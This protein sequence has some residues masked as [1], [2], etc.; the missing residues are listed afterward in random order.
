MKTMND[1]FEHTLKDVYYAEAAIIKA[2]PKMIKA[3][4]ADE[5][6][7]AFS[8]H[9]EETKGQVKRLDSIFKMIDVEPAGEKCPAIDGL[10][11]ECEDLIKD[12]E[13]D[14]VRD[15]AV[16]ACAQAVEHYEISRYGTLRTWASLMDLEDAADLLQETL[17]EEKAADDHMSELAYSGI[18][19]EAEDSEEGAEPAK[20]S[21]MKSKSSGKAAAPVAA[22]K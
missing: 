14:D 6:K 21:S 3:V 4:K 12:A 16:L 17:D 10:I 8:D 22:R 20:P 11:K 18:N 7:A 15:A 1:L 2:L 5:L 9:L 19:A 13:D